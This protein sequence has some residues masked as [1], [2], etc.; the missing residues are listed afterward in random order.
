[1]KVSFKVKVASC[2][3]FE[4]AG[5]DPRPPRTL[6]LVFHFASNLKFLADTSMRGAG[7]QSV[8][9]Q[10]EPPVVCGPLPAVVQHRLHGLT[11]SYPTGEDLF[12]LFVYRSSLAL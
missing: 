2:F 5:V 1:M 10:H 6:R 9:R 4:I 7:E 11:L 12:D 3:C 8:S